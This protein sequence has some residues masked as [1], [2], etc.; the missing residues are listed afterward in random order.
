[1]KNRMSVLKEV[2]FQ[3]FFCYGKALIVKFID[4]IVNPYS[5]VLMME[6]K[7]KI[8]LPKCNVYYVNYYMFQL[9]QA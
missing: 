8:Y 2:T 5:K 3:I 4:V 1:M 9:V 6:W 7:E